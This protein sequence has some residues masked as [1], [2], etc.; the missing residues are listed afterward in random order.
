MEHVQAP[1]AVLNTFSRDT[2]AV[3]RLKVLSCSQPLR[4]PLGN[5]HEKNLGVKING[6]LWKRIFLW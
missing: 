2:C 4:S 6:E 1:V 3:G 5:T